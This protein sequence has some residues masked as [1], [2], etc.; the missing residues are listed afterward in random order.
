MLRA[1]S[2][3]NTGQLL[4]PRLEFSELRVASSVI[5]LTR[6]STDYSCKLMEKIFLYCPNYFMKFLGPPKF[7][8][9][10]G[11]K[12]SWFYQ[13]AQR[14][15]IKLVSFITNNCICE[16]FRFDHRILFMAH[17]LIQTTTLTYKIIASKIHHKLVI[18]M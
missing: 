17:T 10:P 16:A 9:T 7:S 15:T 6:I 12:E 4:Y 11:L 8:P 1:P 5:S 2:D 18:K 3:S 13:I 14:T